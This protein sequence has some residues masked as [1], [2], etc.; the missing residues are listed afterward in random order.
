MF[1][2]S[3]D[4]KPIIDK[5]GLKYKD[6]L[7]SIFNLQTNTYISY[8]TYR[9]SKDHIMRPDLVSISAYN[10]DEQTEMILK[11]NG[12]SNPFTIDED[13][14]IVIP[15]ID[16]VKNALAPINNNTRNGDAII[17]RANKYVDKAK[18]PVRDNTTVGPIGKNVT[19]TNPLPPNIAG[20]G[21]SAITSR[22]GRI[23]FGENSDVLCAQNGITSGEYLAL[24]IAN[25]NSETI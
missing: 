10:T 15:N 24:K 9:V 17:R 2:N 23:Y 7:K 14:V 8:N 12:I 5:D 13:D 19:V 4:N 22:N 25:K 20:E 16:S 3:I 6:L 21:A 1:N 18:I 11:Y